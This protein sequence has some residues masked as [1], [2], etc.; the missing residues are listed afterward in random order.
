MTTAS[1]ETRALCGRFRRKRDSGRLQLPSNR[2]KG[3]NTRQPIR[4]VFIACTETEDTPPQTRP[5][6][7]MDT[8]RGRVRLHPP[9]AAAPA[10]WDSVS[11]ETEAAPAYWDS[12]STETEAAPA[13]WD[14]V[15][16]E[17]VAAPAYWDSVST[18]TEAAPAYWDSV[19]TETEAAPAYWDSV[20]TETE[21]APAYWDSVST[22]T[23]AAPSYCDSVSTETEAA[24]AY[25]DSVS[26]ETEAA[27]AY[28]DFVSTETE[29]APAYWD[30]VSTETEA[31][32]APSSRCACC[33]FLYLLLSVVPVPFSDVTPVLKE[34]GGRS[35]P[36][37][38]KGRGCLH[39]SSRTISGSGCQM[40]ELP[41]GPG[42]C[43]MQMMWFCWRSV[44][45][46]SF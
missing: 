26:T 14:S 29:A 42:L 2:R 34:G 35:S 11:R 28:W 22:E 46:S 39:P 12:V 17:T 27:P 41:S 21:A 31:A 38:V 24:P 33:F 44:A 20:S 8:S 18:E 10:Y 3:V 1:S 16:T 32:P 25:W 6:A 7:A 9:S 19:S 13:Y 15:S 40:P 37:R 30:S 4:T 5:T 23:G 45:L 43:S 36:S